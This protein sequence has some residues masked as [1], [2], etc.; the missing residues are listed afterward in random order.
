MIRNRISFVAGR[1]LVFVGLSFAFAD[2]V[3]AQTPSPTPQEAASNV[4]YLHADALGSI[5]VVTD[6]QG[7][8]ISRLD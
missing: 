3:R 5:R 2:V 1:T 8:V 7:L 6:T 4:E